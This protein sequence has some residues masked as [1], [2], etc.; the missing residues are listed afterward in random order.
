[1]RLPGLILAA[2]LLFPVV[3]HAG[4][5][6]TVIVVVRHAEKATDD[7]NDPALSDA[8]ILRAQALAKALTR[9]P[10]S[11]AY[12]TQYRRTQLTAEPA[13]R[14]AGITVQVRPIVATDASSYAMAIAALIRSKHRGQNVLIIGHSNT[15]P[16][17]VKALSAVTVDAIGE[18]E[19]DRIY[20]VTLDNKGNARL[21]SLRY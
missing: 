17:I 9:L 6:D 11:A 19:F 15:V 8:G 20:V 12:A 14:A 16:E 3:S 21:L 7:P 2:L 1:M 13:A 18:S 10:L 5:R 4:M